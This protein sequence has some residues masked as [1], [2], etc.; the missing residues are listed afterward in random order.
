M[1]IVGLIAMLF[2]ISIVLKVF[3]L[4]DFER[5][6]SLLSENST[7]LTMFFAN[8]TD[9]GLYFLVFPFRAAMN[10]YS[11]ILIG[12]DMQYIVT[13]FL[14][15]SNIMFT[16]LTIVALKKRNFFIDNNVFL[17]MLIYLIIFSSGYIIHHRYVTPIY[18]LLLYMAFFDNMMKEEG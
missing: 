10:M 6:S 14:F 5:L 1:R 9:N 13:L 18:V 11:S 3:H 16:I 15:I 4:T 12:F 7:G 2:I 17:L 8:M